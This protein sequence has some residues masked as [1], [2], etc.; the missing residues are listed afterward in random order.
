MRSLFSDAL[1]GSSLI[2]IKGRTWSRKT[3]RAEAAE[4]AA[5]MQFAGNVTLRHFAALEKEQTALWL[6]LILNSKMVSYR[7]SGDM[8]IRSALPVAFL[9]V[10]V[11]R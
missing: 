6:S 1:S 11:E 10:D 4:A 3:G 5:V 2:I 9:H 7:W 8:I